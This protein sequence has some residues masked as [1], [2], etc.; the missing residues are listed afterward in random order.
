[1]AMAINGH[2]WIQ[3]TIIPTATIITIVHT[4]LYA[5]LPNTIIP[6]FSD[7][8]SENRVPPR[9]ASGPQPN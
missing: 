7:G 1:M 5:L 9:A 3:P 6:I 8:N 2:L 4:I